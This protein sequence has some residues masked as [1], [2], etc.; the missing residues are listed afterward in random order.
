MDDEQALSWN[1]DELKGP[2]QEHDDFKSC[3][4]LA[5]W[6]LAILKQGRAVTDGSVLNPSE[7]INPLE[8]RIQ[9]LNRLQEAARTRRGTADVGHE[10]SADSDIEVTS[11]SEWK[12]E[13][14]TKRKTTSRSAK[15]PRF[16]GLNNRKINSESKKP[17]PRDAAGGETEDSPPWTPDRNS[18]SFMKGGAGIGL[19]KDNTTPKVPPTVDAR[20]DSG[21]EITDPTPATESPRLSSIS[22]QQETESATLNV[23]AT[24]KADEETGAPTRTDSVKRYI[25]SNETLLVSDNQIEADAVLDGA[26]NELLSNDPQI[27][28]VSHELYGLSCQSL[29]INAADATPVEA[30]VGSPSTPAR[31]GVRSSKSDIAPKGMLRL[32]I[33][34]CRANPS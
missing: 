31:L 34:E 30:A 10:T 17:S 14:E 7:I 32:I 18:P 1:V 19:P 20:R 23:D 13:K 8:V 25:N 16:G 22:V 6:V 26:E 29:A 28:T 2:K 24:P 12:K 21:G 33:Y 3:G 4:P 5:L 9:L 15:G 27:T 11:P